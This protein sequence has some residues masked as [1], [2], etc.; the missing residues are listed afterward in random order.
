V[1]YRQ[2][3]TFVDVGGCKLA[4]GINFVLLFVNLFYI[5]HWTV[6]TGQVYP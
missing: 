3:G 5:F 2:L 1:H 6:R 4:S